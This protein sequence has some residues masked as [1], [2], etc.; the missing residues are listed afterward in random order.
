VDYRR[1]FLLPA[2][3]AVVAAAVLL[4]AFWPPRSLTTAADT[5]DDLET[6]PSTVA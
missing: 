4:V 5:E 2:S 6:E 3:M 1:L